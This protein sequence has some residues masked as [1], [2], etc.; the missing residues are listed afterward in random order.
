MIR[1]DTFGDEIDHT[2]RTRGSNNTSTIIKGPS[3]QGIWK[4][5]VSASTT[6]VEVEEL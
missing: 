4:K 5:V 6:H 1:E 3:L 2:N